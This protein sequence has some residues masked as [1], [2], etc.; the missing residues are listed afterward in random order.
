MQ[1]LNELI[2]KLDEVNKELKSVQAKK[3]DEKWSLL[4]DMTL[5]ELIETKRL[6]DYGSNHQTRNWGLALEVAKTKV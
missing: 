5:E 3:L 1:E 2:V 6:I 4:L